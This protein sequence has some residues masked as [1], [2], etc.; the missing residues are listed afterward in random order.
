MSGICYDLEINENDLVSF[1][2]NVISKQILQTFDFFDV[3]TQK[4]K[5]IFEIHVITLEK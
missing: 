2:F 1:S 5:P 3:K 4:G